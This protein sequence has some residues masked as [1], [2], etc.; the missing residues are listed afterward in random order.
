LGADLSSYRK[1]SPPGNR[2]V[3]LQ[4]LSLESLAP[5]P[6]ESFFMIRG[7]PKG[8]EGLIGISSLMEWV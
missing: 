4:R 5:W 8:H 6:L 7:A 2:V 1:G 3:L